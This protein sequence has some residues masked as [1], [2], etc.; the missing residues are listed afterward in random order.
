ML[1]L[2]FY[3]RTAVTLI[4]ED[5]LTYDADCYSMWLFLPIYLTYCKTPWIKRLKFVCAFVF[6]FSNID[7]VYLWMFI[8]ALCVCTEIDRHH[9][10]GHRPCNGRQRLDHGEVVRSGGGKQKQRIINNETD[11]F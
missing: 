3:S 11:F 6:V 7:Q 5:S 8:Y 4:F 2:L 1:L 9:M 10:L